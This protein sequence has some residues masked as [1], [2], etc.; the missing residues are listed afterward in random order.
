MSSKSVVSALAIVLLVAVSA[1]ADGGRCC[2][3]GWQ[4]CWPSCCGSPCWDTCNSSY[5]PC[6]VV[7]L[8]VRTTDR[9]AADEADARRHQ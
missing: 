3:G 7:G 9:L 4:D 5:A 6:A 1:E 2:G 8:P